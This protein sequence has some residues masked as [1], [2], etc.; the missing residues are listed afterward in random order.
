MI[1]LSGISKI[2]QT[3]IDARHRKFSSM[4]MPQ[5]DQH[6]PD[7]TSNDMWKP[8]RLLCITTTLICIDSI[9]PDI[10]IL[11]VKRN[12]QSRRRRIHIMCVLSDL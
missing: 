2:D 6:L 12:L 11:E 9:S 4:A 5:S 3:L 1:A 10:D 7:W 8:I